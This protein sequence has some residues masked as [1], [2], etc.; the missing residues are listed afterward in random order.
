VVAELVE[1]A[2]KAASL[3]GVGDG[4]DNADI[5]GKGAVKGVAKKVG[6]GFTVSAF[7]VVE[8]GGTRWHA[9]STIFFLDS[10]FPTDI[11]KER[12]PS[13][14]TFC[15]AVAHNLIAMVADLLPITA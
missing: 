1:A 9:G 8:G 13:R 6:H 10:I 4:K 5:G 2:A 3:A 14:A 7:G 12:V 15:P 11:R